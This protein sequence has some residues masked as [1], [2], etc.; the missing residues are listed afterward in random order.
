[1]RTIMPSA[2]LS[3]ACLGASAALL[4]L[5]APA[6]AQPF[7]GGKPIEMTV[8]FGAGSAADVTARYLADGMARRLNVPVPVVKFPPSLVRESMVSLAPL[9]SRVPLRRRMVAASAICPVR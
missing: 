3:N 2:Y 8:M 4:L 1:M 7:P 9:R 6:L 5:T